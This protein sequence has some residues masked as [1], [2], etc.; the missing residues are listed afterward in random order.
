[1]E[2]YFHLQLLANIFAKKLRT[3]LTWYEHSAVSDSRLTTQLAYQLMLAIMLHLLSLCC[4]LK[5]IE[6]NVLKKIKRGNGSIRSST[7]LYTYHDVQALLGRTLGHDVLKAVGE[8]VNW[9]P[10]LKHCSCYGEV[11]RVVDY[12]VAIKEEVASFIWQS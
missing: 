10:V 5:R 3:I 8:E 2:D 12:S 7:Y 1:M 9:P 6:N 11:A 4:Q